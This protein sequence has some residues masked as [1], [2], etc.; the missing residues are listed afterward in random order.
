MCRRDGAVVLG[1]WEI[2]ERT[3]FAVDGR[4]LVPDEHMKFKILIM[5]ASGEQ[6]WIYLV[7][8]KVRKEGRVVA[9]AHAA[10]HPKY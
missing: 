5:T 1:S 8:R 4:V 6:L 3:P 7:N 9:R 10:S 2:S